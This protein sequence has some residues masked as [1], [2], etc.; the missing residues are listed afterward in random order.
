MAEGPHPKLH[1]ALAALYGTSRAG[2]TRGGQGPCEPGHQHHYEEI[3][4][5]I[6]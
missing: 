6:L 3:N 2:M 4:K 1:R 5:A